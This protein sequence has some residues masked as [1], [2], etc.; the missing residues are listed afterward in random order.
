[1]PP[2]IP[3]IA[4]AGPP[5]GPPSIRGPPPGIIRGVPPRPY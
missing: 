4:R 3:P 1:M 5:M 2:G